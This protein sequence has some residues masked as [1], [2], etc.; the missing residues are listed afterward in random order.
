[1]NTLRLYS[2]VDPRAYAPPV[3]RGARAERRGLRTAT[4]KAA[5][6]GNIFKY[7]DAIAFISLLYKI[8]GP[9]E[10]AAR[11]AH[12]KEAVAAVRWSP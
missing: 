9:K 1:M 12:T 3:P 7:E 2:T 5:G 4:S 11:V 6:G 10:A 8:A